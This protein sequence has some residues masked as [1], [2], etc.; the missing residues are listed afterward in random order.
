MTIIRM[1]EE[2]DHGPILAQEKVAISPWPDHYNI[3]EEKLA[4]AGGKLLVKVLSEPTTETP[5]DHSK[6]SY[7]KMIKKEDGLIDLNEEAE[8]NYRKVL[9]YSTW[10]G[11]HLFFKKKTG[12]EVRV[13]VKDAKMED[14]KFVPVR[15]IPAGKR[16]MLW[17]DFLRG[18]A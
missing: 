18:N 17:T 3:V 2:M 15:V 1:D 9:A 10:P 12:E 7:T 14:S 16:E 11:A 8:K 4:R 6:A 13:V 5:Q